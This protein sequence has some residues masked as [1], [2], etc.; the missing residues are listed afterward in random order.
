MLT[1]STL[2]GKGTPFVAE[3]VF[4]DV[5]IN[6]Q[7]KDTVL[8]LRNENRLFVGAQEL[9][10][11][12]LRLPNNNPLKFYDEDFYALDALAGLTF[13]IDDTTYV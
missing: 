4:L 6:D 10:R 8:L 13:K 5:F 12:R 2:F 1:P 11:W 7:R 9:Q 3:E